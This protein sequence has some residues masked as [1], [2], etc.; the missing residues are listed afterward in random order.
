MNWKNFVCSVVCLVGM[1]CVEVVNYILE[2]VLVFIVL[3]V[4]GNDVKWYLL[5]L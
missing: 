4:F 5:I 1:I 3:K 2:N